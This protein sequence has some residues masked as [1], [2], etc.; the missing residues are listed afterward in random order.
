[1]ADTKKL[2]HRITPTFGTR[3]KQAITTIQK[4]GNGKKDKVKAD[5]PKAPR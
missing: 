4:A 3:I 2:V 5:G 1:M